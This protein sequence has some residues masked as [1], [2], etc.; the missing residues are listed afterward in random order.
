MRTFGPKTDEVTKE[1][2]RL[3]NEEIHDL[4]SSPN[5]VWVIKST[6]MRWEEHV[7]RM[8]DRR[9]AYGVLVRRPEGKRPLEETMRR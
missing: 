9:D 6:K 4:Y 7:A 3:H 8:G 1:W 5:I 2:R